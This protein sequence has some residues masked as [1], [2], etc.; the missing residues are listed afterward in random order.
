MADFQPLP[1]IQIDDPCSKNWEHMVG[2]DQTR[3]CNACEKNV[4]NF[5]EMSSQ[6]VNEVLSSGQSVCARVTRGADGELVTRDRRD[7]KS[8]Q[9]SWQKFAGLA[10]SMAAALTLAG[11]SRE[12]GQPQ[13]PVPMGAV[14]APQAQPVE[15]MGEICVMPE[16]NVEE[17]PHQPILAG[18]IRIV[19]PNENEPG[20][21][22]AE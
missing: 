8:Q 9:A 11:C 1:V 15:S 21:I 2:D 13:L 17:E 3:F 12:V 18:R 20:Q 4:F 7:P 6:E 16:L 14:V 19:Q 5:A 22:E 10:A